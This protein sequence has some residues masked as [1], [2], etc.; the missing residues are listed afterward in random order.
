V[1]KLDAGSHEDV[2]S[3]ML[4]DLVTLARLPAPTFDEGSRAAWLEERLAAAPGQRHRDEVGNLVW[5]WGDGHP[6]LLVTAHLDTVFSRDVSLTVERRGDALI[7]PG[8][9]DNAAAIAVAISVVDELLR[10]EELRPGGV[11]FTVAEE[12]LGNLRGAAHACDTLAPGMLIALEGHGLQSVFVDAVGSIRARITIVGPGG[13]SWVDR[14]VPSAVHA[15][16]RIC[17]VLL[18]TSTESSPINV[19]TLDGGE[20][21][22]AIAS[23][24]T[25]LVEMR[26]LDDEH[27]N[28]FWSLLQTVDV[29][30]PLELTV[31]EVG[32]R[33]A[34]R[35]SR[36]AKLLEV[37]R[38][39]RAEIGLPDHFDAA[40]TDANA[41][42]A[43][44]ID[45][46]ALGVAAGQG[47]H[48][49]DE[50]IEIASLADGR[51]QLE[52]VLRR[53]LSAQTVKPH[54]RSRGPAA[55]P[56]QSA[57]GRSLL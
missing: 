38:D 37:V 11:V 28:V 20:S 17:S 49:L 56:K 7:G 4:D 2:P 24:A 26:S 36:T 32:R 18:K 52:L 43:R 54:D 14:D 53:L 48:T 57:T 23:E 27:L 42:L 55:E 46:I 33:P 1:S 8:V 29:P 10:S 30:P 40:S 15:L 13:H 31:E 16:M 25:A 45:G 41:A 39:V 51:K 19:G 5:T 34:G 3:G 6:E 22:N 35:L 50:Q 12:G 44:G 47:M 9:G 21:I